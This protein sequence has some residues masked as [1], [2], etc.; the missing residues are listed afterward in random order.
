[1]EVEFEVRPH[2]RPNGEV[3]V[4]E[5]VGDFNEVSSELQDKVLAHIAKLQYKS[6]HSGLNFKKIEAKLWCLKVRHHKNYARI[7]FSFFAGNKIVLL[8]GYLKKSKKIPTRELKKAR[9]L[10]KEISYA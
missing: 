8:N 7:F 1:M 10:L 3:P 9:Q 6:K 4:F 5:A 2:R